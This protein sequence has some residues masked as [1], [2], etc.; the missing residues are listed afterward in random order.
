LLADAS[1]VLRLEASGG[2]VTDVAAEDL[3]AFIL[4]YAKAAFGRPGD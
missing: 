3:T 1:T 4:A 2:E